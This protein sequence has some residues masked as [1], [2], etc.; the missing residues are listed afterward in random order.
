[1][2][3]KTAESLKRGFWQGMCD[4]NDEEIQNGAVCAGEKKKESN[5][6]RLRE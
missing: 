2:G 4:N 6:Q 5:S 1:M 3:K